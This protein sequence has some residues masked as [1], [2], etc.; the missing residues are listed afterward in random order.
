MPNIVI[1]DYCNLK[2][3]YCF[4]DNK[5]EKSSTNI[6]MKNF[7]QA[8]DFSAANRSNIGII[9]GE[10][11]LHPNFINILKETNKYCFALNTN[12]LL[13]TNGI[14]LEQYLSYIGDNIHIL[15]NVN[16]PEDTGGKNY[17]K[18]VSTIDHINSLCWFGYRASCGVT[19]HPNRE[20]YSF[21]WKL[22]DKYEFESIRVSVASPG[23]YYMDLKAD[24]EKYY[25]T[26]KPIFLQFCA[27]AIEHNCRLWLD[28][29][30]IPLCYFSQE[31]Q[32]M[33]ISIC[34]NL[35]NDFCRP[36]IDITQ[37]LKTYSCFGT[38][39]DGAVELNLFNDCIELE[40]YFLATHSFPKA[41][42]ND[43]GKCAT[44]ARHALFQCQGGCLAFVQ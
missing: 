5:D 34:D 15:I 36:V 9:G 13:Y 44:C 24:K 2:C 42:N 17:T 29:N 32:E 40:R 10:P 22:V 27:N 26:M 4:A 16:P 25:N 1:T 31:E 28:C 11:T 38:K 7:K 20:D 18:I 3:P 30:N 14:E 23:G 37:D 43:T 21:I 35:N 33:I 39:K 6:S 12:A 19:L 8:L 41:V